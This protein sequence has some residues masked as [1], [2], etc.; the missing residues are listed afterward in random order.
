MVDV[1]CTFSARFAYLRKEYRVKKVRIAA[2]GIA[3]LTPAF[4]L[5]VPAAAAGTIGTHPRPPVTKAKKSV[6]V[7]RLACKDNKVAATGSTRHG[8]TWNTSVNYS[9]TNCVHSDFAGLFKSERDLA[10]RTRVYSNGGVVYSESDFNG[11]IHDHLT[12]FSSVI[13]HRGEKVCTA[14]LHYS[15]AGFNATVSW[16]PLCM[17]T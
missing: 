10:M 8:V 1:W 14:L 7:S 6:D 17:N 13:N 2:A 4:G 3:G 11:F 12:T 16:G 5:M 15:V 9:G